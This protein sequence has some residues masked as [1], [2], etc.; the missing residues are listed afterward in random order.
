MPDDIFDDKCGSLPIILGSPYRITDNL[1]LSVG[2][3][4]NMIVSIKD[5]CIDR[6]HIN[7]AW[8]A[9]FNCH[10][11]AADRPRATLSI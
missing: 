9:R 7:V 8:D 5:I 2:V 6:P 11:V 1:A 3:A 10:V 4:N